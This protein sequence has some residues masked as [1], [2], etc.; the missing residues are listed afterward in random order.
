M[1]IHIYIVPLPPGIHNA[2]SGT[3]LEGQ[4]TGWTLDHTVPFI[5][6]FVQCTNCITVYGGFTGTLS[7]TVVEFQTGPGVVM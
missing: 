3:C 7:V 5:D 4:S 2:L 1:Y 6:V